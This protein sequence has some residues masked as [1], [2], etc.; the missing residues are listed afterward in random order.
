MH[1]DK[2]DRIEEQLKALFVG[3]NL[4]YGRSEVFFKTAAQ[5]NS[6]DADNI[7]DPYELYVKYL[8]ERYLHCLL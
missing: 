2:V 3:R 6:P 1:K 8:D 4:Q 5:A 7:E